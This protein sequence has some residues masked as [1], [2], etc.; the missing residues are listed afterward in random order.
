VTWRGLS[1]LLL[2][3][4]VLAH[5]GLARPAW[6]EAAALEE[7]TFVLVAEK[8]KLKDRLAALARAEALSAR[9]TR[10]EAEEGGVSG[11]AVARLRRSL[12][13]SLRGQPVTGVHLEVAPARTPLAAEGRLRAEGSFAD[14]VRLSGHLVRPGAGFVLKNVRLARTRRGS[15]TLEVEGMSVLEGAP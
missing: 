13:A 15:L 10:M 3:C 14:V 9:A 7:R 12:L 8:Q 11:D 6:R 2:L 1:I 5:F 4:A